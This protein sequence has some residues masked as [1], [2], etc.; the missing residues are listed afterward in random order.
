MGIRPI[1]DQVLIRPE[2]PEEMTEQGVVI[3][4]DSQSPVRTGIVLA[5][6]PGR[7]D[8]RGDVTPTGVI[9]GDR[10]VYEAFAG[11]RTSDEPDAPLIMAAPNIIAAMEEC[12]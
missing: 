8:D 12:A 7:K 10:V 11:F 5:V 3:P 6:G 1:N 4:R 2:S 9:P